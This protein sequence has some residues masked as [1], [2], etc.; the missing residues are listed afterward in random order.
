MSHQAKVEDIAGSIKT[1][2]LAGSFGNIDGDGRSEWKRLDLELSIDV[3]GVV[4]WRYVVKH[5]RA[6]VFSNQS[7]IQAVHVY[8]NL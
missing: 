1:V 4:H 2:E 5:D 6:T 7:L 3:Q 8:N